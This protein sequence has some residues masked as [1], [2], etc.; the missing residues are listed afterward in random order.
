MVCGLR[1]SD[2]VAQQVHHPLGLLNMGPVTASIEHLKT[3]QIGL[4]TIG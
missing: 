1:F 4:D 2:E 3:Q